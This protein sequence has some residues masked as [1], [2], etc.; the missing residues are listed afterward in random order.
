MSFLAP[1]A[2]AFA[3]TIPVVIV[4][5]LLKR[6]RIVKL[7]SSTV[8]WQRYLAETQASAPFQ[9]LRHNWLLILQI[10]LLILAVLAL[11]HPI[12]S[13]KQV[14]GQF[15]VVILDASASMQSIDVSPSRFA[16]ACAEA[17][18]VVDS[19]QG[20]DQMVVLQASANA[21]VLQSPTSSKAS[22]R[23]AIQN[24][25]V[26]DGPT[27]LSEALKLAETLT[28]DQ[29]YPEIH[30]F[31]DGAAVGLSEFET[32]GLPLIYHQL[33]KQGNNQGIVSLDVRA[34][35]EEPNRRAL[36]ANIANNSTNMQT[37]ILELSFNQQVIE[38][39][40]VKLKPRETTPQLFS[41]SQT[42]DGIFTLKLKVDDDLQVDNEA[43]ILSNL[44]QP[45]KVA[46]FTTGNRFLEKAIRAAS[47]VELTLIPDRS[48]TLQTFDIVVLDDVVPATWPQTSVL[49]IHVANTNWF[50]GWTT[51]NAPPIVAWKNNHPLL[52]FV[53]LDDIQ[54]A[55]SIGV[56]SNS[57]AIPL[58]E[59]SHAPLVL[60]GEL[61]N[62]R[63]IW[64]GFNVLQ[65]TWPL[66]I[67]FP[68][69]IANAIEWL[70][71]S[72]ASISQYTVRAGDPFRMAFSNVMTN[73]QAI[74]RLPGG[75][76]RTLRLDSEIRE[77]VFGDTSQK[78]I[79][80]L[81]IGDQRMPFCVNIL[82]PIESDTTP[83]AQLTYGKY[84]KVQK[85]EM[86]RANSEIWR[87]FA[88][89]A[90]IVMLFEW[91]YYHRRTV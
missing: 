5:Y 83:R 50:D 66:R 30:L 29:P 85:T 9:R 43:S 76:Q 51:L 8:L 61:R 59:T 14:A 56:R 2:F 20:T 52:R 32:K 62:Q 26:T 90:L 54:V 18:K 15:L 24:C 72:A 35:P 36:Y 73:Q 19:M 44:P 27:R 58:I 12:F 81:Q 39:R 31:S 10:L 47:N 34:H 67:S 6:K 77:L 60:A 41:A 37:A 28:R 4:F 17:L 78:G 49:A 1:L 25:R 3:A 84:G 71:P 46:M 63:I 16:S 38:T 64:I 86:R 91:W 79:Y 53:N 45:V 22:L 68:I 55:E 40:P 33:G 21:Q 48:A 87:W 80:E 7:I 65:S 89:A 23:R 82:D 70:N 75:T 57:W 88:M 69:F 13:K 42:H 74:M 11:A